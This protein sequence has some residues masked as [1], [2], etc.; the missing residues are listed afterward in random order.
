MFNG[1]KIVLPILFAVCLPMIAHAEKP[2]EDVGKRLVLNLV[3][4][5]A[6][7]QQAVPD[8]DGDGYDDIAMCFD[9]DLRDVHN[10]QIIG[11]GTDCLGMVKP[12]GSGVALVG[13]TYFHL[14]SGTLI[15]RG[16]TSVQPVF[17]PTVT[18][19]GL[20]VTHITGA[21]ADQNSILG[22]TKRFAGTTGTARLSGMVNMANFTGNVG[23]QISFDCVFVIDLN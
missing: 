23:D 12:M 6:M 1:V 11:K 15:S 21:S 4:A 9:V 22:G 13:T 2:S 14:P 3:G 7:Y 8:I 19:R 5:G 16:K 20:M 17:H 18:P 10:N